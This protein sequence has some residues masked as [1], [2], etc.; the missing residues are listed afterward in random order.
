MF[1]RVL[2]TVYDP[3]GPTVRV[4]DPARSGAHKEPV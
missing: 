2:P 4:S 1:A 3:P